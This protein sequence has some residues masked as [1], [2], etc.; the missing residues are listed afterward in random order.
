[1][2]ITITIGGRAYPAAL[3]DN[4]AARDLAAQL[5][6]T[7]TFRDYNRVEKIADPAKQDSVCEQCT[8]ARKGQKVIGMQIV[9]GVKKNPD[10]PYWDGGQILDPNNGK[11]YRVLDPAETGTR[12]LIENSRSLLI[13]VWARKIAEVKPF[14]KWPQ[15]SD[16]S[17]RW[18]EG[19]EP[20][21]S[22]PITQAVGFPRK[23]L[24]LAGKLI[25]NSVRSY[26]AWRKHLKE[27]RRGL[28][29]IDKL[30]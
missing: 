3:A 1:M 14:Q 9:E 5:P 8:D 25:P 24:R 10:E 26:I 21:A 4:P 19:K 17:A 15:Q 23:L 7:L 13:L 6:L 22:S 28:I 20:D 27:A 16:Y 29:E 18:S 11:L 12:T 30:Q 2:I